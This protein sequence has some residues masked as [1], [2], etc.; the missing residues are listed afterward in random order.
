ME[1]NSLSKYEVAMTCFLHGPSFKRFLPSEW[2]GMFWLASIAL[3]HIQIT[4]ST[5]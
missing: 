5:L 2:H 1:C 4:G 3:S